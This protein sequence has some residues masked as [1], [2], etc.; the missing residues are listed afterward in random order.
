MESISKLGPVQFSARMFPTYWEFKLSIYEKKK[1][2][3]KNL[4]SVAKVIARMF[5]TYWK[6]IIQC[7]IV[8]IIPKKTLNLSVIRGGLH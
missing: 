3:P 4:K 6:R 7:E 1:K 2:T 8:T 5:P